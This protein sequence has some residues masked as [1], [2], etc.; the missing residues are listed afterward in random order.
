MRIA[1]VALA[2]VCIISGCGAHTGAGAA[3]LRGVIS[4]TELDAGEHVTGLAVGAGGVAWLATINYGNGPSGLIRV[5]PSGEVKRFTRIESFNRVAVDAAGAAW[6]TAGAGSAGQQP[7]IVRVEPS[8]TMRDFPLPPEGDFQGITIG[9][10]GAPWFVD[11]ASG[12]V[13][14]IAPDGS[15]THYTAA[16]VDADEIVSAADGDL[17]FT[18]TVGNMIARLHPADG[19]IKEF[20]IPTAKSRPAGI[21]LG[22]DGAVWFCE[23]AAGKIG[24]ITADGVIAEFRVPSKDAWPLGIAAARDGSLWF[25]E[26]NAGKIGRISSNGKIAEFAV[27]GGGQPGPIARA[28]DG[29]LAFVSNGGQTTFGFA[30]SRG[31]LVRFSPGR[32]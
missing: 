13:W 2:S 26:M 23:S 20:R 27:P 9:S 15:L 22:A 16:R 12:E 21:A 17:W 8:G 18:E 7:K 28:P 24:R 25:T 11:A 1:F 4:S 3:P 6:F 14:R 19:T 32:D 29:T 10:D 30:T 31:R 5:K